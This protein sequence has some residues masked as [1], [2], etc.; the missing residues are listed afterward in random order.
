MVTKEEEELAISIS[1]WLIE[2]MVNQLTHI[3]PSSGLLWDG[4][5][6]N[7]EIGCMALSNVGILETEECKDGKEYWR[8]LYKPDTMYKK[9]EDITRSHIDGL[10]L[11]LVYQFDHNAYAFKSSEIVQPSCNLLYDVCQ[12]MVKC[13]YMKRQAV[14]EFKYTKKLD[15]WLI[16][17]GITGFDEYSS[18]SSDRICAALTGIS[19]EQQEVLAHRICRQEARFAN[20]FFRKGS[21]ERGGGAMWIFPPNDDWDINL[22]A[23]VY[24]KFHHRE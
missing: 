6:S 20:S 17:A 8:V 3:S 5:Q 19:K 12:S 9:F 21:M 13:G 18:A 24:R 10:L 15:P 16:S 23:G 7:Y 4:A 1:H 14:R 2:Q 11:G 22:A